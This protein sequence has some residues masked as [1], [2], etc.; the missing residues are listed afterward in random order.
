MG[1][2]IEEEKLINL[3]ILFLDAKLSALNEIE[4]SMHNRVLTKSG[5]GMSRYLSDTKE[6]I[7]SDKVSL[8]CLRDYINDDIDDIP[9]TEKRRALQVYKRLYNQHTEDFN[10]IIKEIAKAYSTAG[11]E[12]LS[13]NVTAMIK[14]YE[15][16]KN[17]NR[18]NRAEGVSCEKSYMGRF[19]H[20]GDLGRDKSEKFL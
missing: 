3:C 14:K 20:D 15:E 16:N 11:P 2:P 10:R 5:D 18:S 7:I 13:K 8:L 17:G 19:T 1:K 9:G 6:G 4:N 12:P